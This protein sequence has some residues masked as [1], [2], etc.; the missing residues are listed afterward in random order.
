M[1]KAPST[2]ILCSDSLELD[3][4]ASRNNG[5]P[6][7]NFVVGIDLP[8]SQGRR[9]VTIR[10]LQDSLQTARSKGLK[11]GMCH[12]CFDILHFGHLRHFESAASMCDLLVVS[13]TGDKFV[14]KGPDRPIFADARRAELVSALYC[15]DYAVVSNFSSAIDI[16]QALQPDRFFKGSDYRPEAGPVNPNFLREKEFAESIGIEVLHTDEETSSSTSILEQVMQW[17]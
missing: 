14:N 12:G 16:L 6:E 13:V 7:A 3:R 1:K 2:E 9:V 15:V 4:P 11:I 10:D 5:H 8:Q 17:G